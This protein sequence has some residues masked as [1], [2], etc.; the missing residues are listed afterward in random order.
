M[1]LLRALSYESVTYDDLRDYVLHGT[2]LPAKPIIITLDDAYQNAYTKAKPILDEFGYSAVANVPTAYIGNAEA[3]RQDNSFDPQEYAV[4]ETTMII[5]PELAELR[6]AGWS[7][8]SHSVTHPRLDLQTDEQIRDEVVQSRD[9]IL[10]RL[11]VVS[12][13]FCYPYGKYDNRVKQILQEEGYLGAVSVDSGIE[14]TPTIRLY[15]MKRVNIHADDTLS[16]F[17][18]KIG[19]TGALMIT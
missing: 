10:D 14:N 16:D 15:D 12:Y 1:G 8:Q 11:G 13:Y 2:P 17:A 9:T 5:W 18:R 7:I 4:R 6:D 3:D 19:H